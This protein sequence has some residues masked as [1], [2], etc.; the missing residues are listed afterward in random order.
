MLELCLP[1]PS[2]T[3]HPDEEGTE[4]TARAGYIVNKTRASHTIPMKREL[5][6]KT[7]FE[8]HTV[9]LGFTHHPD[10]EG[11]ERV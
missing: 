6:D 4:S 1:P 2:F 7:N 10:E 9:L 11:T 3:H 5:K 8:F